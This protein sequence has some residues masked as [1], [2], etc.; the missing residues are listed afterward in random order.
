MIHLQKSKSVHQFEIIYQEDEIKIEINSLQTVFDSCFFL[1]NKL[2]RIYSFAKSNTKLRGSVQNLG[3]EYFNTNYTKIVYRNEEDNEWTEFDKSHLIFK[4]W[5]LNFITQ[6]LDEEGLDFIT[7]RFT[8]RGLKPVKTIVRAI[9]NARSVRDMRSYILNLIILLEAKIKPF[10]EKM[11]EYH[12]EEISTF[13]KNNGLE[14]FLKYQLPHFLELDKEKLQCLLDEALK[15]REI[16]NN[17]VQNQGRA[18]WSQGNVQACDKTKELITL[19]DEQISSDIKQFNTNQ[20]IIGTVHSTEEIKDG[21]ILVEVM[22]TKTEQLYNTFHRLKFNEN[23]IR[24]VA[25]RNASYRNSDDIIEFTHPDISQEKIKIYYD[26]HLIF[27][28]FI[29]VFSE[30]SND[31]LLTIIFNCLENL[32]EN[33]DINLYVL[34]SGFPSGLQNHLNE[35]FKA[36]I[37]E[38]LSKNWDDALFTNILVIGNVVRILELFDETEL[39]GRYRK[40]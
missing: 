28:Y 9:E 34:Y 12:P 10:L 39:V 16:R 15:L 30:R 5:D 31:N 17:I 25:E 27:I 38:E 18:N 21:I 19:I 32:T 23:N 3:R 40:Y 37:T 6:T 13:L 2:L 33:R 24:I 8:G 1:T 35:K 11:G 4:N 29:P 26:D 14:L 20:L 36:I 7:E 22:E